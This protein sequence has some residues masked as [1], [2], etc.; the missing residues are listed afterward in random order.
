MKANRVVRLEGVKMVTLIEVETV[1]GLGTEDDIVRRV[2]RYYAEDGHC[3]AVADSI[4]PYNAEQGNY[5]NY[6]K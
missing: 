1:E 5:N 2:I 3:M 4:F 6:T